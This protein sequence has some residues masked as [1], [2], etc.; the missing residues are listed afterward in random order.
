[1]ID[2]DRLLADLKRLRADLEDDLQARCREHPGLEAHVRGVHRE[3]VAQERT[4]ES[5]DSWRD[6]HLTQVAVAW[7]LGC[8]FVRFLEDNALVDPPRLSGPGGRRQRALDEHTLYFRA[9]PEESY[10]DYLLHVFRAVAALP[11][12]DRIFDE[13]HN[14][15]WSLEQ[16]GEEFRAPRA[17]PRAGSLA[18]GSG[19]TP[20]PASWCTTS[21][22]RPGTRASWATSTR[23]CP[24]AP[25]SGTRCFRRRSSW[26]SSSSTA[27]STPPSR[28][29]ASAQPPRMPTDAGANDPWPV[30]SPFASPIAGCPPTAFLCRQ[31][32]TRLSA[33]SSRN[34][35][36]L[37][38]D[39]V[40]QTLSPRP[41]STDRPLLRL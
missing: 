38:P 30:L 15:I 28:S 29:S 40:T 2:R 17:T 9:H 25:A 34:R 36:D 33:R 39:C 18:C 10:R 11:V 32:P 35:L 16:P 3:A 1:M 22:M 14:P 12:A 26:R 41:E 5:Y 24:R 23:T 6:E 13:A 21:P 31:V 4:A 19:S 20:I 8:V 27:R 37:L 7:I